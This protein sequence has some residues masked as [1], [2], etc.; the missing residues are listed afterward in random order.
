MT[1]TLDL[2]YAH[3]MYA[4]M[5]TLAVFR[6]LNSDPV[7]AAFNE[8][9]RSVSDLE[10]ADAC[11]NFESLLFASGD[12]WSLY[13]LNAVL[14]DENAAVRMHACGESNGTIDASVIRELKVLADASMVVLSDFTWDSAGLFTPWKIYAIDFKK[15]YLHH[16]EE[17]SVKGYGMFA[18]AHVFSLKEDRLVPVRTP[19]SRRLSELPGY[20]AERSKIIANVEALLRGEPAVYMLLYGDAGTGKSSTIKAIANEYADQG[21]RLIEVKK[22]QLYQIPDVLSELADQPLKFILFIDDLSFSTYDD[23][24]AALKAILEG[25]VSE[26]SDNTIVAA[27]SNRRHMIRELMSDRMGDDIHENDTREELLSLSAR[28]GLIVTFQKPDKNR[29]LY[30]VKEVAKEYGVTM[31][32]TEL[33]ERAEQYA[34]RAGGRTPRA[35]RQFIEQIKSG[36]L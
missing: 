24:F 12:C 26:R 25:S 11:G 28:F 2:T 7:V 5:R 1:D 21:L 34:L 22:N 17:V 8:M 15:E 29:Y 10:F 14:N 23:N 27:T 6:G 31:D 35:A 13:L 4:R 9:L 3:V 33:C 16:L 18:E 19:D 20:E 36:V 30:I 32:E